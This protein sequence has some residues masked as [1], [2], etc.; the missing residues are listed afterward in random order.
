MAEHHV[1]SS[2]PFSLVGS[3]TSSIR[4]L[5]TVHGEALESIINNARLS[6]YFSAEQLQQLLADNDVWGFLLYP[7]L[8]ENGQLNMNAAG[9]HSMLGSVIESTEERESNPKQQESLQFETP[10][11]KAALEDLLNNGQW[12]FAKAYFDRAEIDPLITT[13][14]GLWFHTSVISFE[15]KSAPNQF[16]TLTAVAQSTG[17]SNGSNIG[18]MSLLPCPPN[19]GNGAYRNDNLETITP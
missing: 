4:N 18:I 19:C 2:I 12:L 9:V 6:I 3:N 8:D 17:G 10:E 15:D 7:S 13:S 1:S 11:T 5:L 16:F 14:E